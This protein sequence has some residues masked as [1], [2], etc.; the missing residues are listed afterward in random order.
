MELARALTNAQAPQAL[1]FAAAYVSIR[2][3]TSAYVRALPNAQAP[4]ALVFA[5]AYFSIRQHTPAYV[6]IRQ[7]TN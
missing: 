5:A 4:Q 2:Q 1:V 6:S 7:G 3:H